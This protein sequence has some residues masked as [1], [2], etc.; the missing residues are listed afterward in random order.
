MRI[1]ILEDNDYKRRDL[2]DVITKEFLDANI[3]IEKYLNAGINILIKGNFDYAILDNQVSRFSDSR[4]YENNA[5]EEVLEWLYLKQKDTKCII[6]SSEKV[7]IDN[8][9]NLIGI[10]KYS[11]MSID[12]SK[13]L[14]NYLKQ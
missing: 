12:W 1:F 7:D 14:I 11:T 6:C 5:A 9:N 2:L 4:D 3:V 10:V 8:Y 13:Q